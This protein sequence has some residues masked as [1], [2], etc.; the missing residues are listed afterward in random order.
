MVIRQETKCFSLLRI[1]S[2]RRSDR[3]IPCL[4]SVETSSLYFCPAPIAE[5]GCASAR[6]YG[7]AFATSEGLAGQITV[8]IAVRQYRVGEGEHS[9]VA[10]VDEA[11]YRQMNKRFREEKGLLPL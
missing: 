4:G 1:F 3:K 11:L 8:T 10:G 7:T 2:V 5:P 9:F 6:T